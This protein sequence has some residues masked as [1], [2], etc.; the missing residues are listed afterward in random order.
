MPAAVPV[1]LLAVAPVRIPV[2]LAGE[3]AF[4]LLP[5]YVVLAAAALALAFRLARGGELRPLPLLLAA[6]T[7]AFV[8]LAGLSLLWSSDPHEGSIRLIFFL[9]PFT[10]LVAV[11]AQIGPHGDPCSAPW[12]SC[13]SWRR[14]SSRRSGSGS[15][16][17]TGSSSPTTST[18]RTRTRRTSASAGSSRTRASTAAFSCSASSLLLVLLWLGGSGRG[19]GSRSWRSCSS[20][21][22][23]R[24]PS[25][26]SSP[27]R[28]RLVVGLLA[29]D[30]A[31][32]RTLALTSAVVVLLVAGGVAAALVNGESSKRVSSDRLPLVSLTWPIFVDHPVAGVGIGAQNLASSRLEGARE[33]ARTSSHTTPLTVAAELGVLGLAAYAAFLFGAAR[34]S[35][36]VLP[37]RS[38]ARARAARVPHRPRRPLARLQRLLRGPLHVVRA[39]RS[40]AACL[41]APRRGA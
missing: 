19:R 31:T 17:G 21:S 34:A 37:A 9:F 10:L 39:R 29:G 22:T 8:A 23:S 1:A 11:V 32:R 15:S 18:R 40:R 25:R 4:L 41:A 28:R 24:T 7:A 6:P 3:E 26:A 14:R 33:G 20:A 13:S 36:L 27:L 5:L 30:R 35:F 38:G 2:K 16:G 12:S